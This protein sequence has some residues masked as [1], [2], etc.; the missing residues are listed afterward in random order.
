VG[1]IRPLGRECWVTKVTD[2]R[3]KNE[4]RANKE[5]GP[6]LEEK[7]AEQ[8]KTEGE[9]QEPAVAEAQDAPPGEPEE[10]SG[11]GKPVADEEQQGEGQAPEAV[12]GESA[13]EEVSPEEREE[14]LVREN[15]ELQDKFV[16]LMAD[17]D[18]YR[19]R[20]SKEKSDAIQFG[21]EGLL[22][23]I[24]PMVDNIERLLT[25]SYGEGSWK[26]F[27]EGIELLLSDTGK[28]LAKYGVEPI[29]AL[30][31]EFDPN[32]HQAMQRS[33]TDEVDAN[34]VVEVYQKGYTYRGRL[35]RPSL[36]VVSVS[37]KGEEKA[38]EAGDVPDPDV[39]EEESG[40]KSKDEEPPVN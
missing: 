10:T 15:E 9:K 11:Q 34:T 14:Q 13:P 32:L 30:G 37:P 25:Y 16:R 1:F 27:Q 17:F 28:T 3:G 2:G 20:A 22:K 5:E 23:D 31:K 12:E 26:S 21:N 8:M 29:E 7:E 6:A 18:N 36:V 19:K 39:R 24:L 33:E 38:A 40:D 4:S 35:L